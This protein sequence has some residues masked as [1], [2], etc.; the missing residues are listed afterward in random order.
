VVSRSFK[1]QYDLIR[2]RNNEEEY[3]AWCEGRTGYPIVDAGMRQLNETG[4]MHNRLRMVTA[5]FLTKLLLIDWRWGE[6]YFAKK[7]LDFELASNNGGWQW[8]AGTGCDAAPYFRI[9]NPGSQ[10]K[11]FDPKLEY[12][13]TWIS[14]LN[15]EHYPKMIVDYK[16]ARERAL[17]TYREALK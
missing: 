12:I 16:S 1:P 5:S 8:S 17:S 15:T 2:W 10:T 3:K 7:L 11:K 4:Y 13:N 6:A 9:F 14:E